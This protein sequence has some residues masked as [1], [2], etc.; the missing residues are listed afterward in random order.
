MAA[1][2]QTHGPVRKLLIGGDGTPLD[3]VLTGK[4]AQPAD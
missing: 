1:F 3:A 2:E 4:P